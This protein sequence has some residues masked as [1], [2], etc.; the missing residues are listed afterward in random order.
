MKK[1]YCVGQVYIMLK[2]KRFIINHYST[3]RGKGLLNTVINKLPFE[4]H[5]PG[6]QYCG[7]GTK[8]KKRLARGDQGINALDSACKEHDIAYSE[9]NDTSVRNQADLQLAE[10]AWERVKAKDS[11]LG[12]RINAL[13]VTNVMKGK[14]KFGMGIK[15]DNTNIKRKNNKRKC[16]NNFKQLFRNVEL[17]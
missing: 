16:A 7:P 2:R 12:E 9:S 3:V 14:A 6:Y 5:L 4:L 13:L 15:C 8:L 17:L 10:K 11:S 1:N